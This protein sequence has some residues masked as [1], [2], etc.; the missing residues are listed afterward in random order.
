MNPPPKVSRGVTKPMGTVLDVRGMKNVKFA[1]YFP[2][3]YNC[4][5]IGYD[6]EVMAMS[7]HPDN[8]VLNGIL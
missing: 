6:A 7:D 2:F 1:R 5:P 4:D 8:V 3:K